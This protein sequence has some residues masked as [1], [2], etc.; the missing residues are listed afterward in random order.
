V[1][2]KPFRDGRL[3]I[4]L[5]G[6]GIALAVILA[7]TAYA[8]YPYLAGPSLSFSV[9]TSEGGITTLDGATERVSFLEINGYPIALEEDGS[10]SEERAYPPGYTELTAT[11]RD[12]FGHTVSRTITFVNSPPIISHGTEEEDQRN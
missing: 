6:I 4:W 7:Y 3:A 5:T 8:A 11:A 2:P 10:F 1:S 9:R 12:R